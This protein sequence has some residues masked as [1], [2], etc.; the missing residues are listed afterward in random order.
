MTVDLGYPIISYFT[1]LLFKKDLKMAANNG[2][3]GNIWLCHSAGT[4]Q[5]VSQSVSMGGAVFS[6]S[7]LVSRVGAEILS[8]HSF[9]LLTSHLDSSFLRFRPLRSRQNY[10]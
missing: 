2:V 9:H 4:L 7:A 5:P 6:L 3:P 1:Y 10:D 8:V